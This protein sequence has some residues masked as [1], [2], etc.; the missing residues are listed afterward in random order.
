MMQPEE[1]DYAI[2][3]SLLLS[4]LNASDK[5]LPIMELGRWIDA[6]TKGGY[7]LVRQKNI[8]NNQK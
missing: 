2:N 6:K 3:K 5:K 4:W 8:N 1:K 7:K